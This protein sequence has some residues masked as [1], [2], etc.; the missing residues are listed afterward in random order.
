VLNTNNDKRI[1]SC[2]SQAE[3]TPKDVPRV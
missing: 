1:K 3:A 2:T